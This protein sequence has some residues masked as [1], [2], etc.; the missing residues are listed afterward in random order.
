[1]TPLII[2]KCTKYLQIS[3]NEDMLLQYV[4]S[5][6]ALYSNNLELICFF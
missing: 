4:R 6:L 2:A 1:M 5:L 3:P